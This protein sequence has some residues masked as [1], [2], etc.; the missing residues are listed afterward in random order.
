MGSAMRTQVPAMPDDDDSIHKVD[1]VPP[2][3]GEEDAYSAPTRI[4]SMASAVVEE[5]FHAAKA[6]AEAD[7]LEATGSHRTIVDVGVPASVPPPPR[8]PSFVAP[9]LLPSRPPTLLPRATL[10][11]RPP[12]SRP[13]TSRPPTSWAPAMLGPERPR[14]TLPPPASGPRHVPRVYDDDDVDDEDGDAV[15]LLSKSAK[16]PA[17]AAVDPP[18]SPASAST[19]PP[20]PRTPSAPP[21]PSTPPAAPSAWPAGPRPPAASAPAPI[22]PTLV[23][24]SQTPASWHGGPL[25]YAP[26]VLGVAVLLAGIAVF[27][28]SR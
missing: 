4:G 20:A 10:S 23:S 18:A 2:P 13:P 22:E 12:A 16:P 19:A 3:A 27:V 11:S 8:L 7:D 5:I 9:P 24:A 17:P 25:L 1:T 6:G 28:L 21:A 14:S 15:T 26:L